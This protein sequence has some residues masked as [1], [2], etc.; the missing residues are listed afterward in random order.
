[1]AVPPG[2]HADDEGEEED[3][4]AEEQVLERKRVGNTHLAL[5][6]GYHQRDILM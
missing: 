1:M 6:L 5:P 3:S 4:P 2:G